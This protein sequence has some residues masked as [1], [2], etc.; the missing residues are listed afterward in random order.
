MQ[1]KHTLAEAAV[2]AG[3]DLLT[4]LEEKRSSG[5]SR[6]RPL[7]PKEPKLCLP[8][9]CLSCRGYDIIFL[10]FVGLFFPRYNWCIRKSF[11]RTGRCQRKNNGWSSLQEQR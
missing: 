2:R 6:L 4:I 8:R 3:C 5:D 11:Q 10:L 9:K 1:S 7:I